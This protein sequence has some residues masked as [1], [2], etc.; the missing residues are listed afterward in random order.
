LKAGVDYGFSG[1]TRKV[2]TEP[3]PYKDA[4]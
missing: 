2:L 1:D 4:V 3:E